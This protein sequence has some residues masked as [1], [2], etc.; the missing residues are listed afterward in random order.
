MAKPVYEEVAKFAIACCDFIDEMPVEQR[1]RYMEQGCVLGDKMW[2]IVC[3]EQ[4]TPDVH[5][6]GFAAFTVLSSL[7]NA[8]EQTAAAL[9]K[10]DKRNSARGY[11]ACGP[12]PT[13]VLKRSQYKKAAKA[14]AAKAG[15]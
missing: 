3:E 13:V 4:P 5:V 8:A 9:A 15:K 12:A 10:Q 1:Q 7:L 11:D 6:V 14:L 2:N